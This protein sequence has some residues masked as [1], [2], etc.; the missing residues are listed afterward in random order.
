LYRPEI[1]QQ[2]KK[3]HQDHS[4]TTAFCA[5]VHGSSRTATV[6]MRPFHREEK[7]GALLVAFC[8][9]GSTIES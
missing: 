9:V 6:I 5:V 7:P 2:Q 1:G 4:N 3:S 8:V